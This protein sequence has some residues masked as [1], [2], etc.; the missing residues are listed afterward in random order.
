MRV[1]R[2]AASRL[3]GASLSLLHAYA[4]NV[5]KHRGWPLN[6]QVVAHAIAQTRYKS[7]TLN[8]NQYLAHVDLSLVGPLEQDDRK[9]HGLNLIYPQQSCSSALQSHITRPCLRA[10]ILLP[11]AAAM[12]SNR[13]KY[14]TAPRARFRPD[15]T[16]R[17]TKNELAKRARRRKNRPPTGV[18]MTRMQM[19]LLGVSV[20][21]IPML[22]LVR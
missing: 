8:I 2:L 13:K 15:G 10:A 4:L 7:D 20:K 1:I 22:Q 5:A 12:V 19:V 16:R 11:S 6:K 21:T 9:G 3:M 14:G 18:P 17:R